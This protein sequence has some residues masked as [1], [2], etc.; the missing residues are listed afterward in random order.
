[1]K[2]HLLLVYDSKSKSWLFYNH[3]EPTKLCDDSEKATHISI[4]DIPA[5]L[6]ALMPFGHYKFEVLDLKPEF[7]KKVDLPKKDGTLW[8][9][10]RTHTVTGAVFYLS[11]GTVNWVTPLSHQKYGTRYG[12]WLW[13]EAEDMSAGLNSVPNTG[14]TYVP[15][16]FNLF[17]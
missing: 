10:E 9:I 11:P 4:E 3:L 7:I 12:K 17:K 1:M 6:I 8:V 5:A 15:R 14:Y 16:P 13:S 2:K